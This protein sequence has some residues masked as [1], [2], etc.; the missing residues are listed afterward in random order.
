[1][2]K[3]NILYQ[4][5]KTA[6][7]LNQ[8]LELQQ[9]NLP[10]NLANIEKETE[11]FVTVTHSFE[12]LKQMNDACPHIIAKYNGKVIGYALCMTT[13]FKVKIPVLIPMFNEIE[14]VIPKHLSY[15]IMG[16]ICIDKTARGQGVFRGLYQ[17]MAQELK[18]DFKA[19]ITEV[20]IKNTRSLN[21]H[22]AVGF[23][24]LKNYT[25]NSQIWEVIGLN[26]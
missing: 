26:I 6:Q 25:S 24:P 10:Q 20:D 1:M 16:Q 3:T 18:N 7:E 2:Q 12:L 11:G 9:S 14:S 23:K 21:A 22:K 19:I 13:D 15:V 17:F 4:R 5:V 8:I